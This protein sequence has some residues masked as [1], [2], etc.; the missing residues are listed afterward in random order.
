MKP[1]GVFVLLLLFAGCDSVTASYPV[2]ETRIEERIVSCNY[3]GFCFTCMP[4]F[5]GK[6]NCGAKLSSYC[7]GTQKVEVGITP[8]R[9]IH[10][11]GKIEL[12]DDVKQNKELTSCK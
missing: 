3:T 12:L 4:G 8:T 6:M 2:R 7:S 11:S 1:L 9:L 10:K 5:D